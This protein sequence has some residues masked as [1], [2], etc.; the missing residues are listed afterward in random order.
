MWSCKTRIAALALVLVAGAGVVSARAQS[1]GAPSTQRKATTVESLV[2]YPA[3]FHAQPVRVRGTIGERGDA[4]VLTSRDRDVLLVGREAAG[5]SATSHTVEVI[6][7]F[8]DVGR[9]E[10][11]DPRLADFDATRLSQSRLDKAW[12]SIGELLVI[13]PSRVDDAATFPAPSVRAL[14]LD[15][16]RYLDQVVTIRGR[17]RGRNL[18]GDQ[19][20]APGQSRDEWIVQA[21][22]AS[23]W[24]SGRKPKGQGFELSPE[25]R[26]DTNVWLEVA[27]TVREDRGLVYLVATAVSTAPPPDETAMA[28]PVVR[29][30]TR[31]PA[32]EIVFSTPTDGETD[33]PVGTRV[34]VQF[35]RD[36]SKE[37]LAGHLR[38]WYVTPT[39]GPNDL[40]AP[41]LQFAI[42]YLDGSRVIELRFAEPLER[43]RTVRVEFAEG[44]LA[45]DGAPLAPTTLTFTLGG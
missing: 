24:V 20:N 3:F 11:A 44:I 25:S 30:P 29:V 40:P 14:A 15:P 42:A 7:I 32:P 16:V 39:L 45:T 18:F 21:A 26:M 17:F 10:Q 22:D 4:R 8:L 2:S 41:P 31:G 28:E 5:L 19:P 27:G 13:V 23:V 37:S 9:L 33:V 43:F 36:L 35:S 1:R 34:R 6:G 38:V 12:P